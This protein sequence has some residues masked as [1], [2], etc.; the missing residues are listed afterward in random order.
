[1]NDYISHSPSTKPL[2]KYSMR[3]QRREWWGP[4]VEGDNT[5]VGDEFTYRVPDIPPAS[6]G[7]S[8]CPQREGLCSSSTIT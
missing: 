2:K 1:M 5:A 3:S 7:S 8:S 4:N 6:S